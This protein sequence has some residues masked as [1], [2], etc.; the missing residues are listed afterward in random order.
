MLSGLLAPIAA[1]LGVSVG[2]AGLLTSVFAV[3]MVVGAPAMAMAVGAVPRRTALIGFLGLFG[4]SHVFGALTP[5]FGPLLASRGVA[6]IANAGF[7]AITLAS[8]PALVPPAALGRATSVILS[9]VT[10]ACIV[11]V[12]AG[13][14]LGQLLGWRAAFWAI[15]VLTAAALVTLALLT[16]RTSRCLP[17]AP[18]RAHTRRARSALDVS[19]EGPARREWRTLRRAGLPVVITLGVLVNAATFAGFTYLGTL[20]GT[21]SGGFG[22]PVALALFGVGSFA[23]V[24]L[25]GRYADRFGRRLLTLGLP[26]LAGVWLAA[27]LFAGRSLAGLLVFALVIGASAFGIGSTLIAAIVRAASPDAPRIAGAVATTAFNVGAVIGPAAAGLVVHQAALAPRAFWM[28]VAFTAVSAALA[29][30][31]PRALSGGEGARPL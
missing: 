31:R 29:L 19:A 28:G 30:A 4:A 9:G 24:T 22:V 5:D 18:N 11:G 7:L 23:G 3:G 20:A 10:L 8:L 14:V 25:A 1:D 15:A 16:R 2:V 21:L 27:A 17:C 13:T 26:V 6:A 12:P